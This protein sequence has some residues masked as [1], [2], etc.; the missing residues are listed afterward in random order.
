MFTLPFTSLFK[1]FGIGLGKSSGKKQ[2]YSGLVPKDFEKIT[3]DMKSKTKGVYDLF[4]DENGLL[5]ESATLSFVNNYFSFL[6]L[7]F[8]PFHD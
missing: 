7:L 1:L 4:K 2:E 3:E 6:F 8:N 5:T